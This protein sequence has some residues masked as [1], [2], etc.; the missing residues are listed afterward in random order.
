MLIVQAIYF[1]YNLI[2]INLETNNIDTILRKII[3]KCLVSEVLST[4]LDTV[5]DTVNTDDVMLI[6]EKINDETDPR[7]AMTILEDGFLKICDEIVQNNNE[8]EKEY[9]NRLK[10]FIEENY[11]NSQ[12]DLI[13]CATSFGLSESYFSTFFKD[14]FGTTFSSY[15]EKIRLE[16]AKVLIVEN[17]MDLEKIASS[18][19]YSSSAT[20]RRAF[21]R[22][23]GVSPSTWK[24]L[25][26]QI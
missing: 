7:K 24:Q 2:R 1:K 25:A 18:V 4:Y 23:F 10:L 17:K 26:Q 5:R 13:S 15:L 20:F 12:F 3:K 9:H 21:K 19:G 11:K 6:V 14:I 16:K 8:K 22:V